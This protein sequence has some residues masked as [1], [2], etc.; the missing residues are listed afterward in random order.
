MYLCFHNDIVGIY[1]ILSSYGGVL[2]TGDDDLQYLQN[3]NIPIA[4]III[5]A[6]K[7]A[8]IPIEPP[9]PSSPPPD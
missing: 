2:Y 1:F 5:P 7:P 9:P 4:D 6:I 3:T 8:I